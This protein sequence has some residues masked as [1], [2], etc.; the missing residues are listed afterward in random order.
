MTFPSKGWRRH[1]F[2]QESC[3][4]GEEEEEE[5]EA[6]AAEEEEEEEEEEEGGGKG[7]HPRSTRSASQAATLNGELMRHIIL[8]AR[9]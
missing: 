7:A 1:T 2:F 9:I 5:E 4:S 3:G 6:A 8:W